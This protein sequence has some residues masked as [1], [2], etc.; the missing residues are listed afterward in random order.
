MFPSSPTPSRLDRIVRS[1]VDAYEK[2]FFT[3]S[4]IWPRHPCGVTDPQSLEDRHDLSCAALA[5]TEEFLD[6]R[7]VEVSACHGTQGAEDFVK[8][9]KAGGLGGH[10]GSSCSTIR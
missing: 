3:V 4:Y 10:G 9:M 5:H 7:A 8:S 6:R 2:C 1:A